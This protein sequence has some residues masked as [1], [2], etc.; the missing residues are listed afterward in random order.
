M[1]WNKSGWRFLAGWALAVTVCCGLAEVYL[2]WQPPEDQYP[3]LGEDSPLTGIYK[4]DEDFGVT[5]KDW[6]ALK[7]ENTQKW[8]EYELVLEGEE[9]LPVWAFFGNSFV[10]APGM[11]A[12]QMRASVKHHK[13]FNLGKNVPVLLRLAQMKLFLEHGLEPER[14]FLSFLPVDSLVIGAFPLETVHVTM[15]GALTYRPT[16]PTGP[17]GC[18]IARSRLGFTAWVRTGGHVGNWQYS[19]KRRHGKIDPVFLADLRTLFGNLS[20]IAGNHDVPVTVILIPE[21]NQIVRGRGFGFQD[22]VGKILREVG[23]DAFDPRQVFLE[24]PNPRSLYL[25]DKHLSLEGNQLLMRELLAHLNGF[26]SKPLA[27]K[28]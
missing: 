27:K 5:Y 18:L 19:R 26:S 24:H 28:Q 20:K 23:I 8:T 4:P 21:H 6:N 14:M 2:R 17:V 13:I 7:T 10:H 22:D 11:L 15:K 1:G 16:I 3:Y 25:P 9:D 12:D